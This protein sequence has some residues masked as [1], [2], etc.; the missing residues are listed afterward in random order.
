M[1]PIAFRSIAKLQGISSRTK[2]GSYHAN[3]SPSESLYARADI[4]MDAARGLLANA[5]PIDGDVT[6]KFNAVFGGQ[7]AQAIQDVSQNYLVSH[8]LEGGQ[9]NVSAL[10]PTAGNYFLTRAGKVAMLWSAYGIALRIMTIGEAGATF[11]YRTLL[12]PMSYRLLL[13]NGHYILDSLKAED[14]SSLNTFLTNPMLP[15]QLTNDALFDTTTEPGKLVQLLEQTV[16]SAPQT[17]QPNLITAQQEIIKLITERG[18][19]QTTTG[20]YFG[21]TIGIKR[22]GLRVKKTAQETMADTKTTARPEDEAAALTEIFAKIRLLQDQIDQAKNARFQQLHDALSIR[23]SGLITTAPD[24]AISIRA[25][26]ISAEQFRREQSPKLDAVI[27]KL[28]QLQQLTALTPEAVDQ[29]RLALANLAVED[30]IEAAEARL[31]FQPERY[32]S[33]RAMIDK[34]RQEKD[35]ATNSQRLEAIAT[36]LSVGDENTPDLDVEKTFQ[37]YADYATVKEALLTLLEQRPQNDPFRTQIEETLDEISKEPISHA[38]TQHWLAILQ[39]TARNLEAPRLETHALEGAP[40][41]ELSPALATEQDDLDYISPFD[42]SIDPGLNPQGCFPTQQGSNLD[43]DFMRKSVQFNGKTK[44]NTLTT[45]QTQDNDLG[46]AKRVIASAYPQAR[47]T[48]HDEIL[49]RITSH[50]TQSLI[51]GGGLSDHLHA[52]DASSNSPLKIGTNSL[53]RICELHLIASNPPNFHADPIIATSTIS[54]FMF[55]DDIAQ[56]HQLPGNISYRSGL[57]ENGFKPG[58]IHATNS[59]LDDLIHDRIQLMTKAHIA[60]AQAEENAIR[61]LRTLRQ[62]NPNLYT[63]ARFLFDRMIEARRAVPAAA[64][65]WTLALHE[66]I[67]TI[68]NSALSSEQLTGLL[69][70]ERFLA[71][72]SFGL[73]RG[74]VETLIQMVRE[75][76][77]KPEHSKKT[78]SCFSQI[79]REAEKELSLLDNDFRSSDSMETSSRLDTLY[80]VTNEGFQRIKLFAPTLTSLENS[81]AGNAVA[82]LVSHIETGS[83]D[84]DQEQKEKF[85]AV[86]TQLQTKM[87]NAKSASP[88]MTARQRSTPPLSAASTAVAKPKKSSLLSR[89]G[90]YLRRGGLISLI[91]GAALF[92][93]GFFIPPLALP[94]WIAG[95]ALMTTSVAAF[96]TGVLFGVGAA[97]LR[98]IDRAKNQRDA[99]E[100]KTTAA[101]VRTQSTFT[102]SIP[103]P[104]QVARPTIV[105][106]E[107]TVSPPVVAPANDEAAAKPASQTTTALL[108]APPGGIGISPT[109]GEI[110]VT[111]PQQQK[112]PQTSTT[113]AKHEIAKDTTRPASPT[114]DSAAP[115]EMSRHSSPRHISSA[116]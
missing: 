16:A 89:I 56:S 90:Q 25:M 36:C 82:E 84:N 70:K 45:D 74:K 33:L 69:P 88:S 81:K 18:K 32:P 15:P 91:A 110:P 67:T 106:Q 77:E 41:T 57:T 112:E 48:D 34:A 73:A 50:Y 2:D 29:A 107:R 6:Q 30:E 95:G 54:N 76:I 51:G 11:N 31:A 52:V 92:A 23:A 85:D 47:D 100:G 37:I 97:G 78:R 46:L 96:G 39:R 114:L 12:N 27:D 72:Q 24:Q 79:A 35:T 105:T 68:Q 49:A 104:A 7:G 1:E 42:K 71:I 55:T 40:S 17:M 3:W 94:L 28:D 64:P 8:M 13:E 10:G 61:A 93:A 66:F 53:E 99:E 83:I 102:P 20:T 98:S 113:A 75:Q 26:L 63:Q 103:T 115:G 80:N 116:G 62:T 21:A 22:T 101:P 109:D 60:F 87:Q 65:A 86:A 9:H 19:G 38:S 108:S 4:A 58:N 5:L 14:L 59:I 43:A 111:I 44:Q